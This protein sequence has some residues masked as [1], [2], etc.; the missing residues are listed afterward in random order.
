MKNL[1][2]ASLRENAGKTSFIVGLAK[3][4]DQ[5]WGYLK[6]FGDRLLYRKK[7]LWDYDSAVST[8][9][10]GT[11]EPPEEM[12]LGFDHSKLRFMY[13]R[14][15]TSEKIREI[16]ALNSQ[17]KDGMLIEGGMNLRRGVSVNL[18]ALSLCEFLD[19]R[20]VIILSGSNDQIC[21]DAYALRHQVNLSA[22]AL[23]GVV[24]NKVHDLEDFQKVHSGTF[25]SLGLPL[26]GVLPYAAELTFPT[27]RFI[28]DVLFA[29][30]LAGDSALTNVIR[31]TF[32]GAMSADAVRRM[33]RFKEQQ[34]LVITS[35][36][37]SDM[38][39]AALDTQA[40]G[41]ILTNNILPPANVIARAANEN[42]PLLMVQKDTFQ[43]AKIV[44]ELVPLLG[45][46]ETG[47]MDILGS[48]VSQHVN[49]EVL[50]A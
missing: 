20:L 41:I 25:E 10:M 7:R 48:L 12:S 9:A 31:K 44:D 42:I 19:A 40:A 21:D 47:K 15:T 24:V 46:E 22:I 17:G 38:I 37:R 5:K 6:P 28:G 35:G 49:V 33:Q 36:D 16:H 11:S 23:A 18:D 2:I 4:T 30:V 26:L 3:A 13:D 50:L 32:V 8:V 43:T 39:L 34:K 29:K 1:I 27:M 14:D 45:K